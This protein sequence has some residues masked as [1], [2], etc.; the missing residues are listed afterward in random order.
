MSD[1]EIVVGR[2]MSRGAAFAWITL[3][4][5]VALA[6][7][8]AAIRA[9]PDLAPVWQLAIADVVGTL[10]VFAFSRALNNSSVYDP[11]WSVLPPV[12]VAFWMWVGDA[13]PT[14]R[15]WLLLAVTT[16]YGV[17]LTWNWA[18]GWSGLDH[19]DWRYVDFRRKTGAAYWLVSLTGIHLFPTVQV[20]LGGLPLMAAGPSA[21]PLG[22]L[23]IA[24]ALIALGGVLLEG[25]ADNQLRDFRRTRTDASQILDTGVWAWCRHPNYLGE[26]TFWWGLFIVGVAAAPEAWWTGVGALA[27]SIM[28][29]VVSVP[30]IDTRMVARRPHYAERM[31]AVPALLPR[32]P[33]R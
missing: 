22:V 12:F 10:V 33:R 8:I 25:V 17:R 24:G 28:F 3:A 32:P 7:G 26:M 1:S 5:L 29:V 31:K 21:T 6:A 23:D 11:Y 27:I 19:E 14:P 15:A 9:V 16:A 4:Y 20:F 30:L 2:A 13:P 18:R